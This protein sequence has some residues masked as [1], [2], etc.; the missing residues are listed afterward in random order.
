[1]SAKKQWTVWRFTFT[2]FPK[3]VLGCDRIFGKAN[4]FYYFRI[5]RF[6]IWF[7]EPGIRNYKFGDQG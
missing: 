5:G 2:L 3:G 1:M 7:T 6:Y 4:C